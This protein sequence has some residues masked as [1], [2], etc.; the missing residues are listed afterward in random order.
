MNTPYWDK[1]RYAGTILT[2]YY[3]LQLLVSEEYEH[4]AELSAFLRGRVADV[5]HP[6]PP[7]YV[8]TGRR[9]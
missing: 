4:F 6:S 5:V 2:N 9:R 3:N 8:G 7:N 1:Y